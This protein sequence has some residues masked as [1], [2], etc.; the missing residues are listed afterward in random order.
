MPRRVMPNPLGERNSMRIIQFLLAALA[1]LP[2]IFV[3]QSGDR[4]F[5]ARDSM[6]GAPPLDALRQKWY[7]KHLSVM[8][9]T[10]LPDGPNEAYRFL[11]LCAN[12]IIVRVTCDPRGCNLTARRL[13]GR[14][15]YEPGKVVEHR[16][17]KLSEQ[18]VTN[19]R[20]LLSKAQ[21]WSRQPGDE[22]IGLD[23]AQWILEGRRDGSY[24]LWDVWSAERSGPYADFRELW[25]ELIRL[26]GL[27]IRTG[28]VY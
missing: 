18:E 13:D 27:M 2:V 17:R 14:G 12:P 10:T 28:E 8:G 22:R 5:P 21:F 3:A 16:D 7:S 26:S 23:G 20:L 19:V 9:E 11:W 25:L 4:P 24:H 1:A 6:T 15:G